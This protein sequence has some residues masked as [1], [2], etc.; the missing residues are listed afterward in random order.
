MKKLVIVGAGGFGREVYGWLKDAQQFQEEWYLSAFYDDNAKALESYDYDIPLFSDIANIE[1]IAD[2]LFVL[3]I[4][5][6]KTKEDITKRFEAQGARFI[7]LI[8]PSAVFGKNVALGKGC[9]VC[10]NVTLTCDIVTGD[11]VTFNVSS[12]AGHDVIIGDYATLSGHVDVTGFAR[13]DKGVYLGSHAVVIPGVQVGEY[14]NIG[15]GSV[16]IRKVK[17]YTS[18]FGNPAKKIK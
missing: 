6:P 3:A 17:P 8:H 14:A 18:V 10:P 13:I 5:E 16:V 9:V 7:N 12:T 11:F 1:N 4:G 15:A 2:C